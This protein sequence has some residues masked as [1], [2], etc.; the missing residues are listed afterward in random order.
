MST[1]DVQTT[2]DFFAAVLPPKGTY[3]LA[4]KRPDWRGFRHITFTDLERMATAALL[5]AKQGFN[6]Y[7]G[8]SSYHAPDDPK[9]F[10]REQV[11]SIATRSL[12]LDADVKPGDVKFPQS[13]V[14][15]HEL[16]SALCE[17][18]GFPHPVSVDSGGGVHFY[19]PLTHAVKSTSWQRLG[20]AFKAA[21]RELSPLLAAD[22]TRLADSAG[23]LRV[24]GTR[25]LKRDLPVELTGWAEAE[26]EP[27]YV[28]RQLARWITPARPTHKAAALVSLA[29]EE[30]ARLF[31]DV[32]RGCNWM[33]DYAR[34]VATATEPEW[35]AALGLAKHMYAERNGAR[36]EGRDLAHLLS[37]GHPG[38]SP[39]ET[40]RKF[41]QVTAKQ[42]G[43]TM[44]SRFTDVRPEACAGC[45]MASKVTTPLHVVNFL[46]NGSAPSA[47]APA[48]LAPAT[49]VGAA[50]G[51]LPP[52]PFPFYKHP[53][54]N[55]I[56][57][58][59]KDPAGNPADEEI[60]QYNFYITGRS[61]PEDGSGEHLLKAL[62]VSPQD[63]QHSFNLQSSLFADPKKFAGA[64]N[65]HGLYMSAKGI[66]RVLHYV[67][68]C[69]QLLQSNSQADT[70]VA[71]LGW[72]RDKT[73]AIETFSFGRQQMQLTGQLV[74]CDASA[75]IDDN[76][77]LVEERGSLDAWRE[78]FNVY[79]AIPDS[80]VLQFAALTAFAAPLFEFSEY[81]GALFNLVGPSGAGKSTAL[82]LLTSVWGKPAENHMAKNDTDNAM[83]NQL[84]MMNSLPV[85]FDEITNIPPERLSDFCLWLTTGRGKRRATRTGDLA[86]QTQRWATMVISTSNASLHDKLFQYRR[87]YS[88]EAMR[89]FEVHTKKADT[90]NQAAIRRACAI[91][92]D[93]HGLAGRI[94]V[95]GLLK[96][97]LGRV[98]T[99][100]AQELEKLARIYKL[101]PDERFWAACIATTYV[102]G[103]LAKKMGLHSYD[104]EAIMKWA[105]D[106]ID[107][108]RKQVKGAQHGAARILS[109]YINETLAT[110]VVSV[111]GNVDQIYIAGRRLPRITARLEY[112]GDI[113]T[114]CIVPAGTLLEWARMK[115]IDT[116][117]LRQI[118]DDEGLL[119]KTGTVRIASGTGLNLPGVQCYTLDPAKFIDDSDAL[120]KQVLKEVGA[121]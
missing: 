76:S 73:D 97:G 117:W 42:T 65:S 36:L 105:M 11:N 78:A 112:Q 93:N 49:A 38:Y 52:I 70:H 60:T 22:P 88:G 100:V 75:T 16:V 26:M 95:R 72:R 3:V 2:H 111:D 4:L 110:Q 99:V 115:R 68:R 66:E 47:T 35:Y 37:K 29:I 40:D 43:P 80:E 32:L 92:K 15:A 67:L 64:L 25:N 12:V 9:T 31:K 19:W 53:V 113:L 79:A 81:R 103:V 23:V 10:K 34:R 56:W 51:A 18:L 13:K 14:Q 27:A 30:P 71:H 39:E 33:R 90:A 114:A 6:T 44:C 45:P 1:A 55:G 87:G 85:V 120:K 8:V 69:A 62:F 58:H 7:F 20:Q 91:I 48:K 61:V 109:D 96:A 86:K 116:N 121:A 63:G 98:Q 77:A 17:Q 106:M 54:D 107:V 5:T 28:A 108:V 59:Q 83:P 46:V 89:V 102:G 119:L 21:L 118:M 24:P 41:D 84:G 74:E 101:G 94:Y 104:M 57:V 50:A 82:Q